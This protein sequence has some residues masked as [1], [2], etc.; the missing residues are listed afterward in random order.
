MIF[1]NASSTFWDDNIFNLIEGIKAILPQSSAVQSAK[2]IAAILALIYFAYRAYMM[3]TGEGKLDI[4]QL[5]KPFLI[6]MAIINFS[7]VIDIISMPGKALDAT[8]KANMEDMAQEVNMLYDQKNHLNDSLFTT[9]IHSTSE[10]KKGMEKTDGMDDRGAMDYIFAP[11][12]NLTYDLM[13]YIT[14]YEQL[15]YAK[16]SLF[17]QGGITWLVIATFKGVCYCIFFIQMILLY[18][19]AFLGPFSFAFSLAGPF[20]N[21]WATWIGRYLAVS[22]YS[23]IAFI[24]I[25]VALAIVKYGFMQEIQRLSAILA[26]SDNAEKFFAMVLRIDDF[27]GFLFIALVVAIAGIMSI[28][29]AS[30]W[31]IGTASTGGGFFGG[32]ANSVK[33][34]AKAAGSAVSGGASAITSVAGGAAKAADKAW[35]S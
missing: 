25:N 12:Q 2:Q 29:V 32:V 28:P 1:L 22:F 4:S 20:K 10:I 27:I 35:K 21:A 16:I 3:L 24:V 6:S 26:Q 14:I 11:G 15:M 5:L 18:I 19:L 7:T 17:I 9:L 31:I 30:S 23:L 34:T 33:G 13:A 8:G